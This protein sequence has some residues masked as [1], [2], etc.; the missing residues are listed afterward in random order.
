MCVPP[1]PRTAVKRVTLCFQPENGP[2]EDN[3]AEVW[4]IRLDHV[5]EREYQ[6]HDMGYV[7]GDQ[8]RVSVGFQN[9]AHQTTNDLFVFDEQDGLPA[10][11]I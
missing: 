5:R 10:G 9:I 7:R 8:D 2:V 4:L 3:Q 1:M 6:L 11:A